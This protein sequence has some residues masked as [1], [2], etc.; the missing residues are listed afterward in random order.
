MT[1]VLVDTNVISE[2]RKGSR[3][4]PGVRDWFR[5]QPA[6]SLYLSALTMGELHRGVL[7]VARR[8]P[9]QGQILQTWLAD[10]RRAAAGRVLPVTEDVAVEWARLNVPDPRPVV[11][12]LLAATA[13][14]HRLAIVTR[15]A[16][17]FAGVG[18]EVIDPFTPV[19]DRCSP[20]PAPGEPDPG[21][22]DPDR[23]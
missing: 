4:N 8:D 16:T 19:S 21:R 18:V 15:N 12:A 10:V 22:R 11:D 14:V 3:A 9:A 1:G 20:G 23:G 13:V 17:D 5:S 2:L 7:S 6:S